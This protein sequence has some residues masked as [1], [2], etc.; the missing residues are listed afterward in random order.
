[1]K[2]P[3]IFYGKYKN[4]KQDCEKALRALTKGDEFEKIVGETWIETSTHSGLL[5][6]NGPNSS[7]GGNENFHCYLM[8]FIIKTAIGKGKL[9]AETEDTV[10]SISLKYAWSVL[11]LLAPNNVMWVYPPQRYRPVL[12]ST[13]DL[14]ELL[15]SE[16]DR[17]TVG[18]VNGQDLWTVSSNVKYIL[19]NIGVPNYKLLS[20]LPKE[21]LKAFIPYIDQWNGKPFIDHQGK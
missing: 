19:A 21:G 18:S 13:I 4:V 17:Y 5:M 10:F 20:P 3:A 6:L 11:G 15:Y 9:K 2:L 7:L 16:G 8:L 1:M 14:W 12:K